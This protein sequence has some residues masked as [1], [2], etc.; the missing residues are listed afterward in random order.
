[1]NTLLDEYEDV[2]ATYIQLVRK[3]SL[4]ASLTVSQIQI[5]FGA[6]AAVLA[7]LIITVL[8]MQT[9]GNECIQDDHLLALVVKEYPTAL[10]LL[11][12]AITYC[13]QTWGI[14]ETTLIHPRPHSSLNAGV[15]SAPESS[16]FS[17]A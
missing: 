16:G 5:T 4:E 10:P 15:H 13:C 11:N 8:K 17:A 7:A 9:E 3:T 12:H 1:M 14:A 6:H 2:A